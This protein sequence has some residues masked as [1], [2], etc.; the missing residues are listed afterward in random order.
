[1]LLYSSTG[2]RPKEDVMFNKRRT[3]L[4]LAVDAVVATFAFAGLGVASAQTA[5]RSY[6]ASPDIFKVIAQNDQFVLVEAAIK[7]A[8]QSEFYS[9]PATLRYYLT[10]CTVR[11]IWKGGAGLDYPARPA[12]WSYSEVAQEYI[13]I[14]NIGTSECRYLMFMPK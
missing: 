5:P 4:R 2:L 7:P 11:A 10:D 1:V 3:T 6:V 8:Q 12:G 13:S 9:V 14:R